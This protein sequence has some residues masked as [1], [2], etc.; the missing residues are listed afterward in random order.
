MKYFEKLSF[1]YREALKGAGSILR[2]PK[3]TKDVLSEPN[4]YMKILSKP[5]KY[6]KLLEEKGPIV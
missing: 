4:K 5:N 1:D 2:K 6:L 3:K